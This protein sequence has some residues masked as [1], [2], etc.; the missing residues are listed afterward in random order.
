M[1]QRVSLSQGA[2]AQIGTSVR[3][4]VSK[5]LIPEVIFGLGTCQSEHST[6]TSPIDR[7]HLR[8]AYIAT[9]P[10]PVTEDDV[11]QICLPAY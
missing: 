7:V 1:T 3:P 8:N 4:V 2:V 9:N 10:R 11:R 5:F 6:R